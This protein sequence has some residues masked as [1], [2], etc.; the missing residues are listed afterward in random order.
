M[1]TVQPDLEISDIFHLIIFFKNESGNGQYLN[2]T[3]KE[4]IMLN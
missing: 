3:G 2:D 4:Y 1:E